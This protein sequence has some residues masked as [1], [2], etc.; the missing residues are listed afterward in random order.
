MVSLTNI[1]DVIL[2]FPVMD[3]LRESF[4]HA[5]IDVIIGS[6]AESLIKGNP[7]FSLIVFDKRASLMSQMGWF[8]GLCRRHYDCVVDLRHTMLSFFLMPQF[9][10]PVIS[11]ICQSQSTKILHKRDVH[12]NRLRQAFDFDD[13]IQG[14]FSIVTDKED[15][16][17]FQEKVMGL[18]EGRNF[19]VIAPGAADSAKRWDSKGF[20][21]VADYLSNSYKLIFA[22]DFQDV[23]MI[24]DIQAAMK[25]PSISL[26]G[27]INLKQ[28]AFILKRCS[29]AMTH[30]SGVMHLASYL[31]VP[32]LVLWGP[33]DIKKYSPW[34]SKS[35]IVRRS[36]NCIR[37]QN[38]K[39]KVLHNC[40]SFIQVDDV[41]K[42]AKVLMKSIGGRE[43]AIS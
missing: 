31:D 29:W 18:L 24:N 6:K 41:I 8:L 27:K 39:S 1:G 12:L 33:T 37:C 19:I 28:L 10:T 11:L 14:Q 40:M 23:K 13:G 15:E 16:S 2:T 7:Y 36:Q 42:G 9:S 35:V 25:S 38:P 17:F 4:P 21:A 34:S 3:V 5:E 20:A 32:L 26:A 30:D 43:I 22:G